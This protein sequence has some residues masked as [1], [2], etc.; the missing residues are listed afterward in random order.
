[1]RTLIVDDEPLACARLSR[2]CRQRPELQ[3]VAEAGSG[4]AAIAA[5]RAHHPDLVLLDVELQDMTGFDV[6]RAL[7]IDQDPVAIMVT[8]H[9][10]YALQAFATEAV[11][12]LTKP[13]DAERFASAIARARRR[14]T[15]SE[16]A[17]APMHQPAASMPASIGERL[18]APQSRLV[19]ERAHRLYFLEV[20]N[21]DYVES[22]GNYVLIHCGDER[23]ISRNTLKHLGA[24][25]APLGFLRIEKSLL[26]NL[27][28]IAFAERIGQ[29]EFAFTMRG[30]QRLVSSRSYRRA[31][32]EEIRRG[33]ACGE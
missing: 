17:T 7:D 9:P 8:A 28:R 31:I 14:V 15:Q 3:V 11:D 23:Y 16:R 2:M 22:D 20:G 32:I 10:E 25:L 19:G 18:A 1:M 5:I 26:I 6:L 29:G 27:R 33:S 30:G 13:V 21:V 4:A 12:F 24:A